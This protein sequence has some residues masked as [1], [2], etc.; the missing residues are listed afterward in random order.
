MIG[1]VCQKRKGLWLKGEN[2]WKLIMSFGKKRIKDIADTGN[3]VAI[4]IVDGKPESCHDTKCK[5]CIRYNTH[6]GCLLSPALEWGE[7]EHKTKPML[8]SNEAELIRLIT[9]HYGC[10]NQLRSYF[11]AN[12]VK[13][14]RRGSERGY[15]LVFK[16]RSGNAGWFSIVKI[17]P[18]SFKAMELDKEYA[19]EE[20]I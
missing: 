3:S 18:G 11:Q 2:K 14:I 10:K 20:L 15:S 6:G 1:F 5:N 9:E 13:I 8:F 16:D 4:A 7:Q 12:K 19:I 17:V